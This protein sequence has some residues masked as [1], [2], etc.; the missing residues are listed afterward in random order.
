[1]NNIE[2]DTIIDSIDTEM[3]INEVIVID[4]IECAIDRK[5]HIDS[6]NYS[7]N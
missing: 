2:H 4:H 3:E 5:N 1:M 6:I 7:N